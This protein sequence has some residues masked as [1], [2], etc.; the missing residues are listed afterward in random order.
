MVVPYDLLTIVKPLLALCVF[1]L[2][3]IVAILT[4]QRNF[5]MVLIW[6]IIVGIIG[7]F[8]KWVLYLSWGLLLWRVI[9]AHYRPTLTRRRSA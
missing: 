6:N 1:F 5:A 3:T 9:P 4:R 7:L 8:S 2:P